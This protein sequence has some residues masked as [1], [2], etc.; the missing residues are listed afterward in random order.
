ML[1]PASF[2]I[3]FALFSL[4][5]A[6]RQN[7][8]TEYSTPQFSTIIYADDD[9][10][11]LGYISPQRKPKDDLAPYFCAALKNELK[12]LFTQKDA[13]GELIYHKKDGTPYDIYSDEFTIYTTINPEMQTYAETAIRK[14]LSEDLQPAFTNNNLKTKR[15]PFSDTYN[16]AKV[17]DQTI[18]GIMH[19]AKKSSL[20]YQNLNG[21]GISEEKIMKSFEVPTKMKLFSYTGEI[22]TLIT[23]TDSI[24]YYK[25]FIRSGLLSLEPS[26]GYVKAWV[27]GI[28]FDHFPFDHVSQG[29]RQMGSTMRPFLYATA[30]SMGV[31]EPCTEFS[32]TEKYCVE[33]CDPG[34]RK[35]CPQGSV[36][37]RIKDQYAS[38][39]G[40]G[41]TVSIISKMGACSGP[42]T[43]AKLLSKMGIVIPQ[44]QITPSMCL[45]TP[46]V[47][48][49]KLVA[50]NAMFV[51]NGV[52]V[53]PQTILRIE[54]KDGNVIYTAQSKTKEI[55]FSF[56]AYDMI[57]MMQGVVQ[58][59]TSTSLRWHEKWG[60]IEHPTAASVG[61]TQ[62]NSDGW[63]VGLTPDLV[64][65]VWSGG[66][67]KQVR[68]RSMLWGQG[69][70]AAL[71]IYGYFMQNVYADSSLAISTANFVPPPD[72]DPKRFECDDNQ[73]EKEKVNPFGIRGN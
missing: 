49:L 37:G 3:T 70:R 12:E 24:L 8:T 73:V 30:L 65:G 15:F 11:I 45:G 32:P 53:A 16:G 2:L 25:N 9:S 72:Y 13:N 33:P 36:A 29:Q 51:N 56:L 61:T 18:A 20:R 54:D 10:T 1:K 44:D 59:G 48:L 14:H 63:F 60:G 27:G 64:T 31:I 40:G 5:L 71:P 38:Y 62:G 68:F 47:S 42:M 26:T 35:W 67:D 69:A 7:V 34:G 19:R 66:E 50:A 57:Q 43:I 22:D 58:S 4:S 41:T 39:G 17:S 52:Y 21:A 46:D 55:I 6:C 23:P 28:D